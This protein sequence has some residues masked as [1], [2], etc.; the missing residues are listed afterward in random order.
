MSIASDSTDATGNLSPMRLPL[1]SPESYPGAGSKFPPPTAA[2]AAAAKNAFVG[3]HD[4]V[5]NIITASNARG[6][7]GISPL[8]PTKSA[9]NQFNHDTRINPNGDTP[10]KTKKKKSSSSP[11]INRNIKKNNL[12]IQHTPSNLSTR[13][14]NTHKSSK[15]PLPPP[16]PFTNVQS[17]PPISPPRF[18]KHHGH[19]NSIHSMSYRLIHD[20]M[21][22]NTFSSAFQ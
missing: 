22:I 19:S 14:Q 6:M 10:K 16:H 20:N 2:A 17:Y 8:H 1:A 4:I 11:K 7:A 5:G 9:N 3:N 18:R 13:S 15:S 12:V 21:N